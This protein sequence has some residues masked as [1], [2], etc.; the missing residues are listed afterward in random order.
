[1]YM[2]ICKNTCFAHRTGGFHGN[3][4]YKVDKCMIC[5]TTF[6]QDLLLGNRCLCCGNR[7]RR[8]ARFK[9][10]RKKYE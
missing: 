3:Y 7:F 6:K 8:S 9:G 1:M 5:R 10:R 4:S 2:Y